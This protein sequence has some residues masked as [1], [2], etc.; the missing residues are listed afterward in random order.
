VAYDHNYSQSLDLQQIYGGGIGWTIVKKPKETLDL[1]ATIQ[2]ERQSF[3]NAT[4]P[5]SNQSLIGSTF[6]ANYVRYLA[7]GLVFNQQLAYI[8]AWNNLHA[9][10]V[11]ETDTLILPVYKRLSLSVGTVD[12]Y[13]NDPATTV[14]PTKRNSFQF[15]MGATYSLPAPH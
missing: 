7:K 10:S 15:T 2:Y 9:Y 5:G 6:A 8:P 3:L 1:K 12:S 11:D 4:T 13:L 14:P